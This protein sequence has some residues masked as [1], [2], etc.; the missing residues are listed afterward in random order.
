MEFLKPALIVLIVALSYVA[1]GLV[2]QEMA[3]VGGKNVFA[4]WFPTGIALF[5][6]LFFRLRQYAVFGAFA[7]AFC[8]NFLV[9]DNAFLLAL[10][11]GLGNTLGPVLAAKIVLAKTEDAQILKSP[12]DFF[13]FLNAILFASLVSA[14]NGTLAL[15]IHGIIPDS[16]F[17][18]VALTWFVGDALGFLVITP[19]ILCLS[20]FA[21]IQKDGFFSAESIVFLGLLGFVSLLVFDM[22]A[23]DEYRNLEYVPLLVL[24]LIA[25][26]SGVLGAVI[27]VAMLSAISIL[28][29]ADLRGPFLTGDVNTSLVFLQA[30]IATT[31]IGAFIITASVGQT[32]M[33]IMEINELNRRLEADVQ[34]AAEKAKQQEQII[35]E[36][37]KSF[38]LKQLLTDISH[39]WRQPLNVVSLAVSETTDLLKDERTDK[40]AIE[41]NLAIIRSEVFMLSE[42]IS[43]FIKFG[44]NIAE[45]NTVEF[46]VME[47]IDEA[48]AFLAPKLEAAGLKVQKVHTVMCYVGGNREKLVE[49]VLAL[50]SNFVE[51]A[52]SRNIGNPKVVVDIVDEEKSV[53]ISFSDNLGG[54]DGV[55]KSEIF[56]PYVTTSFK[57]EQKGLGLFVAKNTVV[58]DFSGTMDVDEIEGGLVFNIYLNKKHSG[59]EV[60]NGQ[61]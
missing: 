8:F 17:F 36:E 9:A 32:K 46:N 12:F 10:Q 47:A 7:G 18:K 23:L 31:A 53:K 51:L 41:R 49:V 24:F 21:Q 19:L 1:G 58:Y 35:Q 60:D 44:H 50:F 14:L 22:Y 15:Y 27:G 37:L 45:D 39:H 43:S 20:R 3:L 28:G 6:L 33:K 11:I 56:D 61:I 48:L 29:T 25:Y 59:N 54:L 2:G 30:Y 4:V 16:V 34:S 42:K 52:I 38:S 13:I 26:R 5:F 40:K 55:K 57:A